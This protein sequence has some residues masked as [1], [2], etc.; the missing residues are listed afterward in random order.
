[1]RE[2]VVLRVRERAGA[3][4]ISAG[5]LGRVFMISGAPEIIDYEQVVF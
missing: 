1:M 4:S 5:S 3:V 2:L